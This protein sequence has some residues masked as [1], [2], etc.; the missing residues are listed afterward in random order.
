M[1]TELLGDRILKYVTMIMLVFL[2]ISCDEKQEV[3]NN[4]EVEAKQEQA[5]RHYYPKTIDSL[6]RFF[7][8]E[9]QQ[10]QVNVFEMSGKINY[11]IKHN[12]QS[13]QPANPGIDPSLD[14]FIY[15]DDS[16][17]F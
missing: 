3:A 7:L 5:T 10:V 1:V 4:A 8:T 16:M 13:S 6:G 11:S 2:T 15:V 17:R 14:W 9:D 12:D